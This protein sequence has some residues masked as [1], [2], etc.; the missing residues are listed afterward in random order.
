[1]SGRVAASGDVMTIYTFVC[2]AA[3]QVAGMV[4]IQDLPSDG[5]RQHAL[6]LLREHASATTVEVW[7][8]DGVLEVIDRTGGRIRF[9]VDDPAET[10]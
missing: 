2:L 4:D 8:D 10:A 7:R 9:A 5:Y 1:M 3:N 6:F